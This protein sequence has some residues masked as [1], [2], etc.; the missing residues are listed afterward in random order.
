MTPPEHVIGLGIRGVGKLL[1]LALLRFKGRTGLVAVPTTTTGASPRVMTTW[2]GA[3]RTGGS[4]AIKTTTEAGSSPL[5][6][7]TAKALS[8]LLGAIATVE[9]VLA[10]EAAF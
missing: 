5:K 6:A 9:T 3:F 7:I 10:L 1:T 4:T 2:T 8:P